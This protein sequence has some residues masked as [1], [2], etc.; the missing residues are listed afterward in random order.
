MRV[1]S[2][3]AYVFVV[4]LI[5]TAWQELNDRYVLPS[6]CGFSG[7]M[8]QKLKETEWLFTK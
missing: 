7:Q 4:L 6:I 1:K 8:M 5:V 3:T 2:T